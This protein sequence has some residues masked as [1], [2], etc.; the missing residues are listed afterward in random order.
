VT[1]TPVPPPVA[2]VPGG[3]GDG[4]LIPVTGIDFAAQ[5]GVIRQVLLFLG[6]LFIGA[7]MT[8][9]GLKLYVEKDG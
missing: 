4:L 8:V 3:G 9:H 1:A 7:A 5:H 6:M 2:T